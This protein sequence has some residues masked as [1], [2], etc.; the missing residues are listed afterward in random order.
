M[1]EEMLHSKTEV[2]FFS[3]VTTF[4][5]LKS[6]WYVSDCNECVKERFENGCAEAFRCLSVLALHLFSDT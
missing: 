6:D 5:F 4:V 1:K 3:S 2:F